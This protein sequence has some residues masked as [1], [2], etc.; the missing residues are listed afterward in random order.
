MGSELKIVDT[1]PEGFFFD[2]QK[3]IVD[4]LPKGFFY[5]NMGVEPTRPLSA[6]HRLA[7]SHSDPTTPQQPVAP[8]PTV[9]SQRP[10]F[11]REVGGG[12]LR[13]LTG[14]VAKAGAGALKTGTAG[15]VDLGAGTVGIPFTD[16]KR[17]VARRL[18]VSLQEVIGTTPEIAQNQYIELAAGLGTAILP[19]R[20]ATKLVNFVIPSLKK[21]TK[22]KGVKGITARSAE[23]GLAGATLGATWVRDEDESLIRNALIMGGLGIGIGLIPEIALP[24]V[25]YIKTA[26]N[27]KKQTKNIS[28]DDLFNAFVG[29]ESTPEAKAF[30][31]GLSSKQ[32]GDLARKIAKGRQAGTKAPE[33]PKAP[34]P[35][36]YPPPQLPAPKQPLSTRLAK[37]VDKPGSIKTITTPLTESQKIKQVVTDAVKT[38]LQAARGLEARGKT[39]LADQIKSKTIVAGNK[40]KA[41]DGTQVDKLV[42]NAFK[43]VAIPD[44][45]IMSTKPVKT[46]TEA[47]QA[48]K[49]GRLETSEGRSIKDVTRDVDETFNIQKAKIYQRKDGITL[50]GI[51]DG[52]P[53]VERFDFID[54]PAKDYPEGVSR[55]LLSK[56]DARK[57][58]KQLAKVDPVF[59]QNPVFKVIDDNMLEFSAAEHEK[60]RHVFRFHASAISKTLAEEIAGGVIKK[61]QLIHLSKGFL[62]GKQQEMVLARKGADTSV[63]ADIGGY[64]RDPLGKTTPYTPFVPDAVEMPEMVELA[65][66]ISKGKYPGIKKKL[67]AAMG[68]AVGQFTGKDGGKIDILAEM[69]KNPEIVAKVIAH[70]IGHADGWLP[71]KT[72]KKGN[73]LGH[74]ASET[75]GYM[76][77]LLTEFPGGPKPLTSKERARIR[78]A[79]ERMRRGEEF[80]DRT[81]TETIKTETP[82]NPDE[83]LAVWN[84]YAG[85]EKNPQL[86]DYIKELSSAE[87][88][89]IVKEALKGRVADWVTFKNQI[90]TDTV[91]RTERVRVEKDAL[92]ARKKYHAMIREEVKKRGLYE[93]WMIMEELKALTK[94]WKPFDEF[95]NPAF[96]KYRFSPAELYADAVSVLLNNPA[97][98]KETAPQFHKAFFAYI[99]RRPEFGEKYLEIQQ[100]YGKGREVVSRARDERLDRMEAA[101]REALLDSMQ[102]EPVRWYS[103]V[104]T[105]MVE[106]HHKIFKDVRPLARK[107][108]VPDSENPEF[109]LEKLPHLDSEFFSHFRSLTNEIFKPMEK[110]E[111]TIAD[112]HKLG[113]LQKV[114]TKRKDKASPLGFDAKAAEK[115]FDF[116]RREWG[117]DKLNEVEKYFNKFVELR[118]KNILPIIEETQILHP[119]T[120]EGIKNYRDYVTFSTSKYF[121]KKHGKETGKLIYQEI[122]SFDE[123]G[124]VIIATLMKDKALIRAARVKQ[125]TEKVIAHYLKHAPGTLTPAKMVRGIPVKPT[126]PAQDLIA[127]PHLGKTVAYYGPKELARSIYRDPFEADAWILAL[128][129]ITAPIKAVLVT[130]NLPWIIWNFPRDIKTWSKQLPGGS[131]PKA[132]KYAVQSVPDAYKDVFKGLSTARVEQMYKRHQ[133]SMTAGHLTRDVSPDDQITNLILQLIQEPKKINPVIWPF[134][135]LWEHLDKPGQFFERLPKIGA[136]RYLET[137]DLDPMRVDHLVRTRG[138]SPDFPG[139]GEK[140]RLWN[141][142]FIFS[143]SGIRGLKA[144]RAAFLDDPADYTWKTFKYDAIPKLMMY[145]AGSGAV[146]SIALELQA[147]IG[148]EEDEEDLLG[149]SRYEIFKR[150][151]MP[152]LYQYAGY[153]GALGIASKE[154]MDRVPERDLE[155]Y[156][157]IPVGLTKT[158]RAVYFLQP[159][160]FQGQILGGLLWKAI[161]PNRTADISSVTNYTA[162]GIPHANLNPW[163]GTGIDVAQYITGKNPYDNWRGRP[164]FHPMVQEAGGRDR[165]L[166]MMRHISNSMGGT[167]IYRFKSETV[168]GVKTELEKL[169][170]TAFAQPFVRRVLRVS[171]HGLTEKYQDAKGEVRQERMR[172]VLK[173]RN[174]LTKMVMGESLS[175]KER[176]IIAQNPDIIDSNME[177]F[178]AR[179]YGSAFIRALLSA[180]T[181]YERLA[182]ID[183]RKEL[184]LN[185]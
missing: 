25:R 157:I 52:V 76:K 61:G 178:L 21:A 110:A 50:R 81:I 130:K 145:A 90:I 77:H 117:L 184:N 160:D 158:G 153:V 114:Q 159:H 141:T 63:F 93:K 181:E 156:I 166:A 22:L 101:G 85:G 124:N 138:G 98:L 13:D 162:G 137:L 185:Q 168:E 165:R 146:G 51:K 172:I 161:S 16:I 170:G 115:H 75:K 120:M 113:F 182:V 96:T 87:K 108:L 121:A 167:S 123:I 18:D 86:L 3:R 73:I 1:L 69:F 42:D 171:D 173:T 66:A 41:E 37:V 54:L 112:L 148:R 7:R 19:W 135:K 55:I 105:E 32:K 44:F 180:G 164:V 82:L 27:F 151:I 152:K 12:I 59:A 179:R 125:I 99:G 72:L 4:T 118:H 88:K 79:V 68:R 48:F 74:I 33:V 147:R 83:I 183:K 39:A 102:A 106:R 80:E 8:L 24:L 62:T 150:D 65:V 78:A 6:A 45:K 107:G 128:E 174:A 149:G 40:L 129:K 47:K 142:L 109:W 70:E 144:A 100:R 84:S 111:V 176:R 46:L 94:V 23:T 119:Q 136:S 20:V 71:L 169:L 58:I 36:I 132:L 17:K 97:L 35:Q 92:W 139:G 131:I 60:A 14:V 28:E 116:L 34:V 155:N 38:P 91:T 49:E 154:I 15:I 30:V 134:V 9:P 64:A 53:F 143:R 104:M 11:V 67:R 89:S 122:G 140:A 133:I 126:D 177:P 2:D 43:E 163:I 26:R 29:R 10:G 31:A 5:D 103:M 56:I 127:Y 57:N 175:F 95:V